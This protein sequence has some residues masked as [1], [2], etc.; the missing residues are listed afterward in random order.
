MLTK[1]KVQ[2]TKKKPIKKELVAFIIFACA[3]PV[4]HWLIFY[5]FANGS[6]ILMAFTNN[7]G[8][9][10]FDNFIRFFSEMKK[11]TSELRVAFRNTFLT[12]VIIVVSYP[13]KVLVSYFIYKKVPG[14]AIYRVLFFL[15]SIIFSVCTAWV[16]KQLLGVNGFIAEWVQEWLGL[17]STPELMADSRFANIIVILH[18]LWLGFPGDLIIWGG[19]FARIPTDVLEAGRMDGVSWWQEFTHITIPLVWPTLALQMILMLCG[20]FGS[21][22][23]VFLLT[24]GGFNTQTF[25]NWMY[26]QTLD[27]S[28]NMYTTHVYNY[29]SAVGLMITVVAVGISLFVRR[30]TDKAFNDVDF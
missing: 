1:N 6:A 13:F 30:F 9:F 22:G 19:T 24:G 28:G 15:P 14:A 29:M 3:M 7:K 5:V 8:E 4:I 10:S 11:S 2:K 21:G 27:N 23:A 17:A 26:Q 16:F 25:S 18:M 12:F 20:V